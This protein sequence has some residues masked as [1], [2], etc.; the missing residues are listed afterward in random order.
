MF[1]PRDP[2]NRILRRVLANVVAVV[3]RADDILLLLLLNVE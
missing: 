2:A 3:V 1:P